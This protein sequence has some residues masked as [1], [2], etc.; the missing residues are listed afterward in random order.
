MEQQLNKRW[1]L[2]LRQ[3]DSQPLQGDLVQADQGVL[4]I[5]VQAGPVAQ[6]VLVILLQADRAVQVILVQ[7]DQVAQG[8]LMI[9]E[10]HLAD[11]VVL[12]ILEI[13]LVAQVVLVDLVAQAVQEI[14]EIHLV[15]R[16]DL[17]VLVQ[18]VILL[19][20]QVAQ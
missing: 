16:A 6:V 20:D 7:G 19:E 8:V 18:V 5:L 14:L 17:L 2:L 13:H 9:L 4:V 12:V 1:L 15:A 3:L 11:Q 10:I